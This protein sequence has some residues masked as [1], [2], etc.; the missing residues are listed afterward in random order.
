MPEPVF[1]TSGLALFQGVQLVQVAVSDTPEAGGVA[2][3]VQ[4]DAGTM[5]GSVGVA[6]GAGRVSEAVSVAASSCCPPQA[7]SAKA[8]PAARTV[9]IANLLLE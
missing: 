8:R 6:S 9:R 4:L 1:F 3:T 7:T 2:E 5:A